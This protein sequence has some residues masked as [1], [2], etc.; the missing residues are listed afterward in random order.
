MNK[1]PLRL[2]RINVARMSSRQR[3]LG[4]MACLLF[5]SGSLQAQSSV[6]SIDITPDASL[7]QPSSGDIGGV[8]GNGS[9]SATWNATSDTGLRY[10]LLDEDGDETGA[11]FRLT[12]N[13]VTGITATDLL[14]TFQIAGSATSGFFQS[15][16]FLTNTGTPGNPD[17][18]TFT[19]GGLKTATLADLYFYAT[20]NWNIQKRCK[21]SLARKAG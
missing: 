9:G 8:V 12:G 15:Y 10:N 14:D 2:N 1:F 21:I 3:L 7:Y 18:S 13:Q 11:H 4:S 17:T 6:V 20:W 19:I 5:M 16:A